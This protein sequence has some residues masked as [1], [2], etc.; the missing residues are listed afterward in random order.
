M[1]DD[2]LVLMA[3]QVAGFF[4]S[5]PE[6]DAAAGV[7]RHLELFWTGRMRETLDK[8]LARSRDGVA[9]L[10]VRAVWRGGEGGDS[11]IREAEGPDALGQMTSDAG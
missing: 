11:P 4:Q 5:Y 10:V 8:R 3:N 1:Q 9:P 6:P 2:K 7:A